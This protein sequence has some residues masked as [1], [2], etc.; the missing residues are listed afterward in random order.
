M[1]RVLT[2]VL[3]AGGLALAACASPAAQ[4]GG[5]DDAAADKVTVGV[6]P[7]VDVAPIYLGKEKGFFSK[8]GIDLRLESGQG[9]AAIVPGV[10][11][12]QF[13]FGFSNV[14]SLLLARDKG[15]DIKVVA[16]GNASTGED[17][18]DFGAVVVRADSPI[19]TGKDLAGKR[20]AVNTL[21]NIGDTTVRASVR[22]AGGD[23]GAVQFVELA[24]PDMPAA[25]QSG[26]VDAAWVVEPFLSQT[27]A[28]GARVVAWN[29]VDTAPDLTVAA[30]FASGNLIEEEGDLV[31]RF[32]EAMNESLE[33]ANGHPDEARDVITTYTKITKE[34]VGA[35]TLPKWPAEVNQASVE[36]LAELA[37]SDGLVSKQPD[38]AA[39]LP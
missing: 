23:P 11:S 15:L 18:K 36:K 24:F 39:L 13:Q 5:G 12:G 4:G 34:Q 27:K 14:T 7:I 19:R 29:F 9:G 31:K 26:R 2:A 28:S 16:S 25:L 10:V 6:I 17:G 22:K 21:K 30:Y 38:V 37:M 20:V 3:A 33:Y 35:L 1:R 8:R 32:T